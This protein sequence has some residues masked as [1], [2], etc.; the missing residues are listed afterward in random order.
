M[1]NK[2][3]STLLALMMIAAMVLGACTQ[4]T[5]T[6]TAPPAPTQAAQ[7]PTQPPAQPTEA[8]PTDPW[9]D[10]DPSGQ[11][12][13]FWHNHSGPR[14]D[15]LAKMSE[16]FNANNQYGITIDFEYEG[17]YNDIF[18]KMLVS[19]N[20]PDAPDLVVAYQNQAATYQLADSLVDMNSLIDSPKW[21]MPEADQQDF[22][23]GFWKQDIFPTYDN[24]RLGFP[25][26]RSME[27]L[28]YNTDWLKELGYDAPPAT[29]DQ[30]KEMACKAKDQPFSKSTAEGSLGYEFGTNDA[31]HLAAWTFAY[32][33]DIYD[34]NANKFTYDSQAAVDSMTMVQDLINQGCA[35][36]VTESF[37]DQTDFGAGKLLFTTSSSSGLPFYQQAVDAGAQFNWS[38][39]AIPHTTPDPV[40][41]IYGA[42][43]SIP[44]TT[45][46]RELAA[47]IFLKYFT[48]PEVQAEWAQASGYF[49]VRQSVANNLADYFATNP[50]YKTGFDMLKYGIFEPPVPGYDFIRLKAQDA[51]AAIANGDDVKTALTT[52]NTDS[53]A[54][55]AE[56]MTSPL[57]TPVPT[58]TPAP[59][60][61]T[62]AAVTD[63]GTADHPIKVL[64]V[65]SVEA[66]IITSGGDVM[67]KALKDAT[68]LEFEVSVPTSYAA[69]IEE[70]CAS[71]TDTMGFIPAFG[72][73]LA[74]QLC[75]VDV[76]FKAVR[77]GFDVYWA[78]ILV[79]R[80]SDMQSLDD[81]NGKKWGYGDVGSTSGYLVPLV[82][83]QDAGVTPG[84]KVET[85]GHTQ[86]V[87]AVYDGS[88]DF[89]TTFYSPPQKPAGEPAWQPGDPPDIPDDL[90]PECAPSADGSKLMCGDW[91]V[92]DARANLRTDAPDVVQKLRILTISPPIP[93][94]TLSFGPDFPAD[95]R[96]KVSDALIAFSQTPDWA[97]SI[98]SNDFYGWTGI[99]PATDAEYDFVRKL[100]DA[101]GVT[102]ESLGQ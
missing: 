94:D 21:G 27:V 77:F 57:P 62:P 46:E 24:A 56:Q 83:F 35:S 42:S 71:P 50:A 89:S 76:A 15:V 53:N 58:N 41:N 32:G 75:G 44:K 86:S 90:V 12:V 34:Y 10:V 54:I 61:A 51:M 7:A 29:P 64:F 28:Y 80:D 84:E 18:N 23:P 48:T 74:N 97:T 25:G 3:W 65:P 13:V 73:V 88:V 100:V 6:P 95:V 85:G 36:I 98:G 59:P 22:F 33:G 67:A 2:T 19:L 40:M 26:Y 72:Y 91:Q 30:F 102:L 68:G 5:P 9:A 92:L 69:T 43:I 38:V 31:S 49:P 20:T 87:K 63:L 96:A 11:T 70:M 60:T 37:G 1:N 78:Q 93:N 99:N 16:D 17:S 52:A 79:P 55:L 66:N 45:P 4:A 101:A 47:W 39:A 81:L 14:A 82:M 8:M